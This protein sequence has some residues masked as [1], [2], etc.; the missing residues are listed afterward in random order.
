LIWVAEVEGAVQTQIG[1]DTL[2]F[3]PAW[4]PDGTGLL[5][6]RSGEGLL[7]I[8]RSGADG[9]GE[10]AIGRNFAGEFSFISDLAPSPDGS[11]VAFSAQPV[12]Q[13]LESPI[14]VYVMGLDGGDPVAL[15]SG[16]DNNFDPTWSPDGRYIAP[17]PHHQPWARYPASVAASDEC[18]SAAVLRLNDE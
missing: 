14:K 16:L 3:N 10:T 2:D 15:T 4:L 11:R 7:E 1:S 5:Y 9:S 17:P 12:D 13:G 18:T 6:V 8:V